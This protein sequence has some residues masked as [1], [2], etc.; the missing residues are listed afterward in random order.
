MGNFN[1]LVRK[2]TI[3]PNNKIKRICDPLNAI[4]NFKSF[5]YT[6]TTKH[7]KLFTTATNAEIHD[8]YYS[9]GQFHTNPF[10]R[11]PEL[12]PSGFHFY[13]SVKEEKF[14]NS[15]DSIFKKFNVEAG[16]FAIHH[17][18]ELHTFGYGIERSEQVSLID[19]ITDN[20]DLLKK[21]N[22]YFLKE[23]S[24]TI[25]VDFDDY[26]NLPVEM[27]NKYNDRFTGLNPKLQPHEKS[28]FLDGIGLLDWKAIQSLSSRELDCLKCIFLGLK[29][30]EAAIK[31]NLKKRTVEK[32]IEST[33]NKLGC[34]SKLELFETA[35]CLHLAEY[36]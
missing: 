7:G 33:K 26:V 12:I 14:Q 2:Y 23:L 11:N 24:N 29:A 22:E 8:W 18:D 32:Y 13:S 35:K 17:K 21:F 31:L 9:T 5:W 15:L 1:S 20:S 19:I 34:N 4:Y 27:G 30:P 6:R 28:K 36:F 10:Y 16:C 25:K 3:N